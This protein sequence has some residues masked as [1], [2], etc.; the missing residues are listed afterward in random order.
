MGL[1]YR[2]NNQYQIREEQI[3]TDVLTFDEAVAK[4]KKFMAD[5]SF[6]EELE[7]IYFDENEK[8][9]FGNLVHYK[10]NNSERPK[11]EYFLLMKPTL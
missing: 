3:P 6:M 5:I 11:E 10:I 1:D 8:K 9:Y 4:F 2:E 7:R